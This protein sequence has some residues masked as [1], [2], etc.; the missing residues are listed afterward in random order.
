M[1]EPAEFDPA[2][3]PSVS[4]GGKSWP[5]PVLVWRDLKK[6]RRELIEL[7]RMINDGL[8]AS[9]PDPDEEPAARGLRQLVVMGQVFGDLS[10]D[11]FDRLV[12]GPIHAGLA[13][14]HP[15]LT[16]DE[17]EGWPLTDSERQMAWLTV[18]RQSGL[19]VFV[20]VPE[21]EGEPEDA[22]SGEETGAP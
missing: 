15:T 16:R 8:A 18:R 20:S 1:T 6:C 14:A 2:T 11:D 9:A 21:D 22:A 5:I 10:N 4:L 17:L 7:N 19:F 12:M 3:T 13:A